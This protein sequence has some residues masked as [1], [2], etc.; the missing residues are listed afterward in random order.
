MYGV[1]KTND[2]EKNREIIKISAKTLRYQHNQVLALHV[3]SS[4]TLKLTSLISHFFTSVQ[5]NG[6]SELLKILNSH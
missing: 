4:K 2:K 6:S 1:F 5:K 3:D